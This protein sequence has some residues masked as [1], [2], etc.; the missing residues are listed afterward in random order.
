MRDQ[1]EESPP[2]AQHS[3]VDTLRALLSAIVESSGDAIVSKTLEGIITSWNRAA[4]SMFGYSAAEA[5]GQS[6]RLII[7]DDRQ[8]EEDKIFSRIRRG[9]KV[10]HFET[11]RQTKDGRKLDISLTVS[12]IRDSSGRVVGASKVA[13]DIT[14]SK[15]LQHQTEEPLRREQ[16]A[17]KELAQ[18]LNARDEFLA[19]AAL[20]LRNPLHV[21]RLTLELLH[22]TAE[23]PA[24]FTQIPRLIGRANTHLSRLTALV[25]RLLDVTRI[26]AGGFDLYRETLD[27]GRLVGDVAAR[28]SGEHPTTPVSVNAESGLQGMWDKLRLEQAVTNLLSNA[29][30][31]GGGRP[32]VITAYKADRQVLVAVRD[33]GLGISPEDLTRIFDQ[34]KRLSGNGAGEGWG[35]GLWITKR[36]IEAHGGTVQAESC[37]GKGSVFT[38]RLPLPPSS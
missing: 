22:R 33:E 26:R 29:I 25:D 7:P 2:I 10:D 18:A 31:Y 16:A 32:V 36:I 38:I 17:L 9:E 30:K 23:D 24:R 15:R 1:I 3:G 13:R 5:V 34:F 8:E 27:L 20:E 21:F 28:F 4:E 6:I 14:E 35:L 19:V 11:V 37:V 12:P